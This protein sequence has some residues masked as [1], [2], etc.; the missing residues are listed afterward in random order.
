MR[1]IRRGLMARL[2]GYF[3]LSSL[4]PIFIVGFM[5]YDSGQRA[6]EKQ[7]TTYLTTTANL[8]AEEINRWISIEEIEVELLARS[9]AVQR[10]APR[11]VALTKTDP[12]YKRAYEEM[13][14]F[15]NSS[16][17]AD[18]DFREITFLSPTGIAEISTNPSKVGTSHADELY[19]LRG[20]TRTYTSKI[21]QNSMTI[22]T[23]VMSEGNSLLGILLVSFDLKKIREL[24][25]ERAGLGKTGETYLVDGN[26]RFVTNPRVRDESVLKMEARNPAIEDCIRGGSGVG[27]YNNYEGRAVI[28]SYRWLDERGLCLVAE[29][30][31]AEAF[32]QIFALRNAIFK[33]GLVVAFVIIIAVVVLA[34]SITTPIQQLVVGAEK[35]GRGDLEHRISL[36]SKDE[37]GILA[38]SFNTMVKNLSE[39]QRKLIQSEKLASIGQLAAGVAHELNNPLANISLNTEMLMRN[40]KDE[41]SAKKLNV[42]AENVDQ[43]A[44]IVRDLLDFSREAKLELEFLDVNEVLVKALESLKYEIRDI[45]IVDNLDPNLP[46]VLGDRVRLKQ[47]FTNIISNALH[48][49]DNGGV[50]SISTR[51]DK[52]FLEVRISDTGRGIPKEHLGKIFDPFFTTKGVGKGTGLGLAISYSIVEKHGGLIEVESEVGKGTTFI[53]KIPTRKK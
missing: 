33:V 7:T 11:V 25:E 27:L 48:A 34:R 50:L 22:S 3:M 39:T 32:S 28:G 8:R 47:V 23:P 12:V 4:V 10:N 9:P 17:A 41:V 31:Q 40:C 18:E 37:I 26:Y 21:E 38:N 53:I 20:A 15:F 16:I 51:A 1:L 36:K 5:A 30:E 49:M 14:E 46:K 35:I 45:K 24:M 52:K 19:F 44:R 13:R 6:I 29:I 43:A 42:I 2:M